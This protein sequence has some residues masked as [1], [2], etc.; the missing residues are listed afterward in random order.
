VLLFSLAGV[1]VKLRT[2]GGIFSVDS[3][4]IQRRP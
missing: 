2:T 3:G 4:Y 1:N